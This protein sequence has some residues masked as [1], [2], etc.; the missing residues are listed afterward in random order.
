MGKTLDDWQ[1]GN[2]HC[3]LIQH[4]ENLSNVHTIDFILCLAC[5]FKDSVSIVDHFFP[6]N[7]VE[8]RALKSRQ[9]FH[10]AEALHIELH[11]DPNFASITVHEEVDALVE[12]VRLLDEHDKLLLLR[13]DHFIQ[14]LKIGLEFVVS[15]FYLIIKENFL[16]LQSHSGWSSLIR[17][18]SPWCAYTCVNAW[19][20]FGSILCRFCVD[21]G[22][23]SFGF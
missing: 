14:L 21:F 20:H 8:C 5:E 13:L 18:S 16:F 12:V 3:A 23:A 6:P 2:V 11:E 10:F 19:V 22:D 15:N 17:V 1:R 4:L 9:F 7:C